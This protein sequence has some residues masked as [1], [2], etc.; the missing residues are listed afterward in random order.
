MG[1]RTNLSLLLLGD[2]KQIHIC[3]N[4]YRNTNQRAPSMYWQLQPSPGHS[5]F[6]SKL[7]LFLNHAFETKPLYFHM[8]NLS[9][10]LDVLCDQNSKSKKVDKFLNN[11]SFY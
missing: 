1:R 2:M 7:N 3:S 5:H 9:E 4:E 11:D 6:S 8:Q 10:K